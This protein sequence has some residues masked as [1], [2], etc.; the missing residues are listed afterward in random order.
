[1]R[2]VWAGRVRSCPRNAPTS[3]WG[4]EPRERWGARTRY[5][6]RS[7]KRYR[8]TA[9]RS[10]RTKGGGRTGN[11]IRSMVLATVSRDQAVPLA[12]IAP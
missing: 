12:T 4:G 9:A 6:A 11:V 2:R 1:M 8:L 5:Y 7:A 3:P 10:S